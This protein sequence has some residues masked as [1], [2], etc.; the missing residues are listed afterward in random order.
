M[1]VDSYTDFQDAIERVNDS[2]FGLQAGIF[3]NQ[4]DKTL[5]AYN[6]LE[7][8]GVVIN[9]VPTFRID[10][11]PYGGVKDSGFGREGIKYSL[12][13]MTEIKLLVYNHLMENQE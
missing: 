2:E 4:M 11:M 13:E 9:D 7:V 3:T 10:N 12:Q 8:G 6:Q 1:V 5:K